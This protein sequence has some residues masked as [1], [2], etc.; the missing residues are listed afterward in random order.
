MADDN[1]MV[2]MLYQIHNQIFARM[3]EG[4][5]NFPKDI[6]MLRNHADTALKIGEPILAAR[7]LITIGAVFSNLGFLDDALT[8][9]DEALSRF[10]EIN[11][12]HHIAGVLN[13]TSL[14]YRYRAQYDEG[15]AITHRAVSVMEQAGINIPPFSMVLA[16]QGAFLILLSRYED[17]E[18]ILNRAY[19]LYGQYDKAELNDKQKRAGVDAHLDALHGL[20][21]IHLYFKRFDEAWYSIKIAEEIAHSTRNNIELTAIYLTQANIAIQDSNHEYEYQYYLDRCNTVI[22]EIKLPIIG[23]RILLEAARY[24][25]DIDNIDLARRYAT[26]AQNYFD[27]ADVEEE[28][29]FAATLLDRL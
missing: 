9:Y 17:A 22:D 10:E 24:Q 11:S 14:I 29:I 19:D 28:R 5:I 8:A 15:L 6:D 21:K 12:P 7:F 27:Q 16:T 1:P 4:N 23:A 2:A 26:A 25:L 3:Y 13:N 18:V 20:A